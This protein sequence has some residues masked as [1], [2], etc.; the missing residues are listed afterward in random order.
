MFL[1]HC[2]HFLFF[3]HLQKDETP[4]CLGLQKGLYALEEVHLG[5]YICVL[6]IF[7]EFP[8]MI[9]PFSSAD[10]DTILQDRRLNQTKSTQARLSWG[11]SYDMWILLHFKMLPLY[12]VYCIP[13]TLLQHHRLQH[14]VYQ[15]WEHNLHWPEEEED[16]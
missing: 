6:S 16:Q 15:G 2:Y 10:R 1:I 11:N 4:G 12:C 5:S 13:S 14:R 3:L 7:A 8:K 9:A